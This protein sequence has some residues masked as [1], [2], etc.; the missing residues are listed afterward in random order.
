MKEGRK[1]GR[2]E[3]WA[4]AKVESE[5]ERRLSLNVQQRIKLGLVKKKK[6]RG[7]RKSRGY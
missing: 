5:E 6:A 3:N 4:V 7:L 1:E 2:K